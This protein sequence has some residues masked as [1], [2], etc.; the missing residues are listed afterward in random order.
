RLLETAHGTPAVAA[1][2]GG[3]TIQRL[4]LAPLLVGLDELGHG[5][6]DLVLVG[7]RDVDLDPAVDDAALDLVGQDSLEARHDLRRTADGD[8]VEPLAAPAPV[9]DV[10]GV[11]EVV[12]DLLL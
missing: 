7:G 2:A 3:Q 9:D 1:D 5:G 8:P 11:A 4:A 6:L 12:V 10:G